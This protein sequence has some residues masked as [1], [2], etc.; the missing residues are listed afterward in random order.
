MKRLFITFI[1]FVLFLSTYIY[2]QWIQQTSGTDKLLGTVFFLNENTGWTA[3]MDGTILK[4]TDGGENWFSQSIVTT[5]NIRSIYFTDSLNGWIALYEWNPFRHGSIY[6]STD[7]GN[8]WY[9]Q[10]SV[11]GYALLS[12]FFIDSNNGWVV[13]TNGVAYQT[14]NG[15]NY[16]QPMYIETYGGWL[17]SVRFTDNNFGWAAGDIFGQME[18]TSNGGSY[19]FS[20]N[21][22]TYNYLIDVYCLNQNLVWGVGQAGVIVR[23]TNGGTNWFTSQSGVTNELRDVQF[24]NEEV[25]WIAGL[26]G[27]IIHSTDGGISWMTQNS[28]TTNDLYAV[29]F[30]DELTGWV[31]GNNGLILKTDN[32]GVPVELTSFVAESINGKVQ[33]KWTTA[34]EINNSG[35]QV[36]RKTENNEF[37]NIGF[38]P[39]FGTTTEPKSYSFIDENAK[40]GTYTYRLKQIDY[41]G[42]FE[43]S[44]DVEIEISYLLEFVLEQNFPN[45]FNPT[46]KIRYS[47]KDGCDVT[48][49]V[50]DVL[51]NKISS[52][53]NS[54]QKAGIYEVIF[55]GSNLSSGIYFYH[56]KAG[57]FTAIK[58]LIL[59]K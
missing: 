50:Y 13:G 10:L 25:G 59:L 18:K 24:I 7:G 15:G 42:S 12:L 1:V 22:P 17:Y 26:G 27:V 23:S 47:L 30:V 8:T 29:S 55:N 48:L 57:E 16:W 43:Y 4:T 38:V 35:F 46:T 9:V 56:L 52:L 34:T 37:I 11:E 51:G 40:S 58:K 3:G 54:Y 41:D 6:H 28:N 2:P 5:D 39:G 31:V 20:Q 19:W 14:V 49:C 32:G 45:P 33:L 53:V 21:I 44:N 36:E